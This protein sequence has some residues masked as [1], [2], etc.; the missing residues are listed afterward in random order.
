VQKTA[1]PIDLPFVLWIRFRIGRRMHQFNR[2]PGGA[3]VPSWRTHC[4]H[5]A[6][7][8]EPFVHG[9]DAPYY[10]RPM[11]LGRPLYFLPCGVFFFLS[12]FLSFFFLFF[13]FLFFLA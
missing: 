4:R 8:I 9:S 13:F 1:E 5:L 12:F 10:D 3:Y 2:S 6:N 11:E 7:T